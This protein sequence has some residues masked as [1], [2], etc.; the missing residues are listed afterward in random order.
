M[1]SKAKWLFST[2]FRIISLKPN[3]LYKLIL[4]E[5]VISVFQTKHISKSEYSSAWFIET[6]P[7][8]KKDVR[9]VN[10]FICK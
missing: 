4:S 6:E 3:P 10:Y 7:P 9:L 1:S 5:Y 8:T 2:S